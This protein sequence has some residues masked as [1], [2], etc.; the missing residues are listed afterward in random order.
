[1]LLLFFFFVPAGHSV[2]IKEREKINKYLNLARE[3]RKLWNIRFS[4]LPVVTRTVFKGLKRRPEEFKIIG[5]IEP[6]QTTVLLRLVRILR[7]FLET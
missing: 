4:E 7:R 6:I 1:M 2:K 3:L 5:R